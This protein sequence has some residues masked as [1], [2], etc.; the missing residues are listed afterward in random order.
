[1]DYFV[2][3]DLRP[4]AEFSASHLMSALY[5][6]LHRALVKLGSSGVGVSFPKHDASASHLGHRMRLH[7]AHGSLMALM[8]T[9]WL[10]GIRD[11]VTT[12]GLQKVPEGTA[13]CVVRRVQSKSNPDRLRRRLMRRHG[14][15]AQEAARRI[16]DKVAELLELP[17][18]HLRSS[19]TNQTFRL[20]IDHR[21][22]HAGQV[23]GT[24]NAYGLSP[25]ATVPWF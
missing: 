2:D 8:A 24:F 13:H 6:K 18:V 16:S 9:D 15:D 19:T 22:S 25:S 7:G 10:A 20:F 23:P 12:A 14:L 11:H 5:A 21:T 1:M 17:F 4:D 3:I